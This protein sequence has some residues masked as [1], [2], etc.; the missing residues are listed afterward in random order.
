M[1]VKAATA[2]RNTA[3]DT[4]GKAHIA[5][6]TTMCTAVA[7]YACT[8]AP[9][10]RATQPAWAVYAVN[11]QAF[12]TTGCTGTGRSFAETE[13]TGMPRTGTHTLAD[14]HTHTHVTQRPA[15]APPCTQANLGN[16]AVG[17]HPLATQHVIPAS[18]HEAAVAI[19]KQ[20]TYSNTARG[21]FFGTSSTIV[22][23]GAADEQDGLR[24]P[25]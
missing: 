18:L 3:S 22:L 17:T 10:E 1:V 8:N 21:V 15:Q 7:L 14:A 24:G 25:G 11:R 16:E 19:S 4:A 20:R 23:A 2:M 9:A 13:G 5:A 6:T 12:T